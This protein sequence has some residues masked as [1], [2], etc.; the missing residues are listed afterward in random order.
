M[1][2]WLKVRFTN[3]TETLI[4][5][6]KGKSVKK[7][8]LNRE[9]AKSF[10]I[11]KIGAN[12]W[13]LPIRGKSERLFDEKGQKRHSIQKPMEFSKRFILKGGG[14]NLRPYAPQEVVRFRVYIVDRAGHLSNEV[15]LS[16]E[17]VVFG[18][19]FFQ[20]FCALAGQGPSGKHRH[21]HLRGK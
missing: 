9:Y 20:W 5:A 21:P 2:N 1:P 12:V 10:G 7:Y 15:I 19:Q 13:V 6:V 11:G 4:W 17:G 14:P 3:A 8:T 16:H 18:G